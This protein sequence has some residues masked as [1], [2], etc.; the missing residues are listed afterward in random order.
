MGD[1]ELLL[2]R[3]N[4][5]VPTQRGD[6][7]KQLDGFHALGAVAARDDLLREPCRQDATQL[8]FADFE[9]SSEQPEG[10]ADDGFGRTSVTGYEV[11]VSGA[12]PVAESFARSIGIF[13]VNDSAVSLDKVQVLADVTDP[14]T[15][16][17][18]GGGGTGGD[19]SSGS[20]SGSAS[21]SGQGGLAAT[22]GVDLT[23]FALLALLLVG[24]G[25]TFLRRKRLGVRAER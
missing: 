7:V 10:A 6:A 5:R 18:T 23:L 8:P 4:G 12:P 2:N 19:G 17:G 15:G 20:G 25:A 24:V 9:R 21:G 1:A 14:G 13:A 11:E 22:G 16:G 3:L